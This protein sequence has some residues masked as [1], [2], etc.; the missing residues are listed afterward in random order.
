MTTA[1]VGDEP[2][3]IEAEFE[4]LEGAEVRP[5]RGAPRPRRSRT[6]TFAHL[7]AA[8][9]AASGLG[10]IVAVAVGNASS[11]A[12]TGTL[13]GWYPTGALRVEATFTK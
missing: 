10:A 7:F 3:P 8:S 13:R 9:V 6:V 4:P 11:G 2:E 5:P 12:P 1:K